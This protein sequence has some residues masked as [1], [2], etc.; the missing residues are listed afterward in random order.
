MISMDA[1]NKYMKN[2]MVEFEETEGY[3]R[4]QLIRYQEITGHLV[5][6]IKLGESF[7][8]KA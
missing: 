4:K 3:P 1:I 6:D 2:V 7:R 5:F 8:L